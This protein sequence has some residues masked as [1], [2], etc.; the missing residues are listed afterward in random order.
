MSCSKKRQY[1]L[2]WWRYPL[3]I[4]TI[5]GNWKR[6]GLIIKVVICKYVHGKWSLMFIHLHDLSQFLSFFLSKSNR[7]RVIIHS[8]KHWDRICQMQKQ[9]GQA[10]RFE[11]LISKKFQK[12][13]KSNF[14][15]FFLWIFGN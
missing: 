15:E 7:N 3:Y 13:S 4:S 1:R 12:L 8:V 10:L 6:F 9:M 14:W 5:F 2:F 11:N